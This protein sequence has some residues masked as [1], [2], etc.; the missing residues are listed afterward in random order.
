MLQKSDTKPKTD[1]HLL[2]MY[3]SIFFIICYFRMFPTQ[4]K[5]VEKAGA[6]QTENQLFA[7]EVLTILPLKFYIF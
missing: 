4:I 7:K 1:F 6:V 3:Y 5:A 2:F